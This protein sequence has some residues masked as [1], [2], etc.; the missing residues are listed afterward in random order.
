MMSGFAHNVA[1]GTTTL[2]EI[3]RVRMAISADSFFG[4]FAYATQS[5]FRIFE[6]SVGTDVSAGSP[7]S[8]S[9]AA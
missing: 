7:P 5:G 4:C 8:L 3:D 2:S 1:S 6:L 9:E